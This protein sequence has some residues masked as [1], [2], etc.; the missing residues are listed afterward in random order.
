MIR[1]G[2][3]CLVLAIV[4]GLAAS[5]GRDGSVAPP[6][7]R[8]LIVFGYEVEDGTEIRVVTSEDAA[9]G[10]MLDV[11]AVAIEGRDRRIHSFLWAA[12]NESF[13][14]LVE[15]AEGD[16]PDTVW[17]NELW[18]MNADGTG[19]EPVERDFSLEDGPCDGYL[20]ALIQWFGDTGG[21]HWVSSPRCDDHP[22][23]PSPDGTQVAFRAWG[24]DSSTLCIDRPDAEREWD[25]SCSGDGF[26]SH[27]AW[28]PQ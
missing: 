13:M 9:R 17:H 15:R 3:A 1:A 28:S 5:S 8:D 12:D 16:Y 4:L 2:I 26:F 23:S 10:R 19:R 25:A 22:A 24:I 21:Y 18:V 11:Q 14:Y 20:P 7:A 6:G 27:P